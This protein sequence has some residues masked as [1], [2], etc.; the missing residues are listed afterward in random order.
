MNIKELA[1][2]AFESGQ[3][4]YWLEKFAE[5]VAAHTRARCIDLVMKGTKKP[6]QTAT[7]KAL[8][9]DRIRIAKLIAGEDPYLRNFV[10]SYAT[11]SE[12]N[13]V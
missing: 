13:E 1:E 4:D 11:P 10:D 9:R 12:E 6:V 8:E 2:Q 5:L 3:R 7:L